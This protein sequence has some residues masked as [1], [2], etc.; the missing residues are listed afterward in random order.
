[1]DVLLIIVV[2]VVVAAAAWYLYQRQQRAVTPVP[3]ASPAVG[4]P[5]D[6]RR[7]NPSDAI[8]FWDGEDDVIRGVL[9]CREQVGERTTEWQW[10]FLNKGGLI[11]VLPRSQNVYERGDVFLQGDENF[12]ALVGAGGALKRFEANI[13]EGLAGEPTTVELAGTTYRVRSTGTFVGTLRGQSPESSSIFD[14]VTPNA[15]DNVYFKMTPVAAGPDDTPLS[16]A[17]RWALGV[18]TTH[19]AVMPGRVLAGHEVTGIY[20]ASAPR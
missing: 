20:P 2:L 7:L 6:M 14:D 10:V 13:R 8:G 16:D 5:P 9:T 19:I 17:E 15:G 18:W 3:I 12:E 1:M 11:E 4:G